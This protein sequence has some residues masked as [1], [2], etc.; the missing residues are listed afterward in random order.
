MYEVQRFD[1]GRYVQH[2]VVTLGTILEM[3]AA[4]IHETLT[5]VSVMSLRTEIHVVFH[6]VLKKGASM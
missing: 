4:R 5:R 2:Q 1:E 3:E 6:F